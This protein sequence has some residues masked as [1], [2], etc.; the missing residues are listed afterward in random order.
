[1]SATWD[2]K[3]SKAT[4]VSL[5]EVLII[6]T[7]DSRNQKRATIASLPFDI[8]TSN[9]GTGEG[10]ALPPV[11]NDFPFKSLIGTAPIVLTG[12]AN[13]VTFTLNPLT[14]SD[15]A[16]GAFPNITG[17]ATWTKSGS[18]VFLTT[19]TDFVG[20]G[21]A[22]PVEPLDV[23]GDMRLTNYRTRGLARTIPTTIDDAIDIGTF[24]FISG[25]GS[26][27]ITI[28]VDLISYSVSKE[29]LLPVQSNQTAG[30]WETVLPIS[31]TGDFS[32]N[33]FDLEVNVSA[34]TTSLRIRNTSSVLPG[35]AEIL[36]KQ[37]GDNTDTFVPSSTVNS[38]TPPTAIFGSTVLTQVNGNLGI[39]TNTPTEKFHQ[40]GGNQLLE[41]TNPTLAG[42]LVDAVNIDNPFS[43]YVV[44][45][46][47]YITGNDSDTFN[48]VDITDPTA[49]V[50]IGTVTDAVV[51]N[52]PRQIYVVGNNAYVACSNSDNLVIIDISDPTTPIIV[53]NLV[54]SSVMNLA[55]SVYVSGNYAYVTGSLS[56]SLA[57]IDIRDPTNP[58]LVGSL[59]DVVNMNRANGVYVVGNYAYVTGE[60]GD[61]LAIV[62]ISDPTNPTLSGSLL[63]SVNMDAPRGLYVTGKYAYV[64][65]FASDSLAIIDVS[66]PSTPTLASSLLDSTNLN[67]ATGIQ[68]SGKYAYVGASDSLNILDVSDPT[69]T[70]VIVGILQDTSATLGPSGVYVAGKF[71][72]VAA[73]TSDALA[74]VD[75]SGLDAPS[76]SI[77]NIQTDYLSV[78]NNAVISNDLYANS[79]NA[80]IGGIAWNGTPVSRV[81]LTAFEIFDASDFPAPVAGV[82]TLPSGTYNI[83]NSI[84]LS[85]RI[86]LATDAKVIFTS[87]DPI[88][89][90]FTYTGSSNTF[91]TASSS[92]A[93]LSFQSILIS[94]TGTNV[95]FVDFDGQDLVLILCTVNFNEA[96]SVGTQKLGTVSTTRGFILDSP[97]FFSANEGFTVTSSLITNIFGTTVIQT[98]ALTPGT[99]TM[100]DFV[101]IDAF[102]SAIFD[103]LTAILNTNESLF[104]FADTITN[105]ITLQ[106]NVLTGSSSF[107]E[108]GLFLDQTDVNVSA[109]SNTGSPNSTTTG[110]FDFLNIASPQLVTISTT[111]TAVAIAGGA[112]SA[113]ELERITADVGNNGI[114]TITAL[115]TNSYQVN[116]SAL[117]EK[118]TGGS[119]NIALT[120]LVNGVDT[121]TNPPRSVNAGIIQISGTRIF[122]LSENDTLQLAV[123][124]TD[125]TNNIEVS[126]ATM[127][128]V[129]GA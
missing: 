15:L 121:T 123:F 19:L 42:S 23:V 5:D 62:D 76:A 111:N 54:D 1:M 67:A 113:T 102:G 73:R 6:D 95:E 39:G 25:S 68:V 105:P 47:A 125:D 12:N 63:D 107:Y 38:V 53:G 89:I 114:A 13:D 59:I 126:Q 9:V 32:G 35:P 40:I 14:N 36:I 119:T 80:G 56:H 58:V 4:P 117:L 118:L 129:G 30:V 72:Y 66:D 61:S 22:A 34:T 2:S 110:E 87:D 10:L 33:D 74:I 93:Q 94:L 24:T 75:I 96:V 79:L 20:I 41:P 65:G 109:F 77:G 91:V 81:G 18:N 21:I 17:T 78:T 124:N 115:G 28:T 128:I 120:I 106:G 46:Y 90:T 7:E 108:S 52:G 50:K 27:I 85:D 26:L 97:A 83:K 98:N 104:G 60:V 44:G 127:S 101:A 57:V 103:R 71:A 100:F 112:W 16:L 82:I 92:A 3:P 64:A 43:V 69:T 84:T 49:P 122:S 29:Y 8:T 88:N 51:L 45:K 55:L 48:V 70:P 37:E 116:F 31:S 99:D 11:G 86:A